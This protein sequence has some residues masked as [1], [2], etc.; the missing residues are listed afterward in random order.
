MSIRRLPPLNALRAFE[1]AARHGNF[2]R[3]AA[4]LHVT[5]AA[6]SHQVRALEEEAGLA[7]FHRTGRAVVLTDAGRSLLPVLSLAFDQI[8]EGWALTK[9]EAGGPVTVSVEPSFAAR[10]LVLRLGKFSRAHPDIDLRLIP[11]SLVTDFER[12]DVD[13]GIRYGLGGWTNVTSERLFEATV[14][15]VCA[16][17]LLQAA[18]AAGKPIR[19]AE[20]LRFQTLIH[21]ETTAHWKAWLDAAGVKNAR[22]ASRGPLFVEAS[23]A[24]QAAA[25]GQGVA[26]GNDPLAM[27]DLLDGR[28]VRLFELETPDEEAYWLVYPERSAR[29]AKVQAF[30]AWIREE[31]GLLPAE[32]KGLKERRAKTK[33]QIAPGDA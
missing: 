22:W 30:R 14:Y 9:G 17:S 7:L 20:D 32:I 13:I 18:E 16:P 8:A 21:E 27:A 1:A 19:V 23:L 12:Q 26:L 24:L 29:K 11:S 28:L 15:P 10:W 31:A 4:E 3:A 6:I 33:R 2:S 25:A 5:H